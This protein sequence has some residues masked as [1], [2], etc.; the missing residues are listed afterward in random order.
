[1]PVVFPRNHLH[2]G[3]AHFLKCESLVCTRACSMMSSSL[4]RCFDQ[5]WKRWPVHFVPPASLDWICRLAL[6]TLAANLMKREDLLQ[7]R[8]AATAPRVLL[9]LVPRATEDREQDG[10]L[11]GL[12]MTAARCIFP[13]AAS[14]RQLKREGSKMEEEKTLLGTE[15]LLPA[16]LSGASE[17]LMQQR[18]ED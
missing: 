18:S 8:P 7:T 13:G 1:M 5:K 10:T 16:C 6:I 15:G 9:G 3:T 4:M 2:A 17:R 11:H 12:M 14:H